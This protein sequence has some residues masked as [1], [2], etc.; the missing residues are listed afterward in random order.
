VRSRCRGMRRSAAPAISCFFAGIIAVDH[1]T[2]KV[3]T[4][5]S[6]L[7]PEARRLAGETGE[8][9]TDMKDGSDRRA[10]VVDPEQPA[11]DRRSGRRHAQRRRE[12]DAVTSG[13]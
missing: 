9:S 4:G 6:D 1:A 11:P 10:V 2:M 12:D 5:Y 3:V 13:I 7:P 8:L